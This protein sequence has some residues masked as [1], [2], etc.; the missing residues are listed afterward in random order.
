VETN[1]ELVERFVDASI[2]GWYSFLEDPRPAYGLIKRD[3]PE[4]TDAQLAYSFEKLQ[5]YGI[6]K[7]GDALEKGIGAMTD[8]RWQDF[9]DSM[10]V[11]GVFEP[12]INY[13]AAYTL[14]FVNKGTAYYTA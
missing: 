14:D 6:I 8:E 2:K 12:T 7:S 4:M 13:Q 1:P 10:T 3:N 9:F 5:E 11:A